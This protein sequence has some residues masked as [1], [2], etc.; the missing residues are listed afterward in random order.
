MNIESTVSPQKTS[1]KSSYNVLVEYQTPERVKAS[2]LG[3]SECQAEASTKEEALQQL[4]EIVTQQLRDRE[5]VSLEIEVPKTPSEHSWMQFAGMFKDDPDFDEL[6]EFI[7][8]DRRQL[9]SEMAEYD[10]KMNAEE[11]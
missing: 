9:D 10:R 8:E 4:Q 5:I 1:I 2:I 11:K 3:W 6:L 7:A